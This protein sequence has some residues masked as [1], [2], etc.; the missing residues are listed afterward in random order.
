MESEFIYT[1]GQHWE[2][3]N[4]QSVSALPTAVLQFIENE[5]KARKLVHVDLPV[6]SSYLN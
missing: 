4:S 3:R 6:G 5:A 2:E 1:F